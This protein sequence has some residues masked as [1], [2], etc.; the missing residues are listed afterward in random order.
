VRKCKATLNDIHSGHKLALL[1]PATVLYEENEAG[2]MK[3]YSPALTESQ[4]YLWELYCGHVSESLRYA[5]GCPL[6]VNVN[7]DICQGTKHPGHWVS[8]R[9]SDQV[10]IAVANLEPWFSYANLT[11]VRISIGTAAHNFG[12][13]AAE[14]LVASHLAALY[15]QVDVRVANHGLLTYEG[16]TFDYA[17]HG[18]GK[19]IRN[20]LYGNMARF[21][22]RDLM[23]RDIM[24]GRVPPRVVERAHA[25]VKVHEVLETGGHTS[26]LFVVPSY[27]MMDDYAVQVTKSIEGLTHGLLVHECEDG[28]H[29]W[30]WL[31]KTLDVRMQESL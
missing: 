31:T 29:A 16:V 15:P 18:P 14:M 27:C 4:N 28:R 23:Q 20:W 13:G 3:P 9:L 11:H 22:L 24:A 19:G 26:D 10:A 2:E 12:I 6:L 7:G 21:Y 30:Q 17:H 1:N 8:N 25:H 5:D